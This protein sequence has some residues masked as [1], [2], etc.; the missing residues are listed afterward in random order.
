LPSC[1]LKGELFGDGAVLDRGN[2]HRSELA[3]ALVDV[4]TV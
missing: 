4:W 2:E 3:L 1:G